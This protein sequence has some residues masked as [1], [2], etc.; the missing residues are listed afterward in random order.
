MN[1]DDHIPGARHDEPMQTIHL[2]I[3]GNVAQATEA[4]RKRGVALDQARRSPR[5]ASET[6]A[7]CAETYRA[8]VVGWFNEPPRVGPYPVG[9]LLHFSEGSK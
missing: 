9:A 7:R 4:A 2:I 8:A 1:F 5:Y 3:K 6:N